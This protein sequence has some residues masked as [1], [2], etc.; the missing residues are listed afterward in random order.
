MTEKRVTVKELSD[1]L[2]DLIKEGYGDNTVELSINY[3]NCDHIQPL[4]EVYVC[5]DCK[6]IDWITLRGRSF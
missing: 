1:Y 5:R 6:Y 2:L 4:N 3:D